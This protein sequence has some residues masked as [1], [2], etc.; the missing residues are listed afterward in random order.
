M[1]ARVAVIIPAAGRGLRLGG[2]VPARSAARS[3]ARGTSSPA[4]M[5][6]ARSKAFVPLAGSPMILHALRAFERA[7]SV[8]WIIIA[9]RPNDQPRLRALVRR[10]RLRKVTAVV[11]GGS[12]RAGSVARGIAAL[13]DE[14]RWVMIHDAARPCIRPALIER[15]ITQAV[16]HGAVACGLP[17]SLTIKAVDAS[18]Q[19]RLTL[20][21]E[22][23]WF[24]QTPQMF[25]RDWVQDALGR[26][27]GTLDRFPDDAAMVEWAGYPVRMI[28]GDPLN[29]KVT[30]KE[31]LLWAAAILRGRQKASRVRKEVFT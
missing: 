21:R 10:H 13:P 18:Q 8:R 7:P 17:A 27:N 29:I 26:L 28:S 2:R 19:V 12:S 6:P 30:T 11:P 3:A 5:V 9:V 4:W 23:L 1:T 24:V 25:R 31:D 20:D 22:S 15:T 16:R 14:A